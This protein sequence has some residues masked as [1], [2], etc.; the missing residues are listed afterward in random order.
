MRV[1]L[2]IILHGQT[3]RPID[4][5]PLGKIEEA[6]DHGVLRRGN[7]RPQ[8]I[9]GVLPLRAGEYQPLLTS[10]LFARRIVADECALFLSPA[11]FLPRKWPF[12]IGNERKRG[13]R[14]ENRLSCTPLPVSAGSSRPH[15][16]GSLTCNYSCLAS[17]GTLTR[18][19]SNIQL[20]L[21]LSF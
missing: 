3:R 16:P 2:V 1:S 20:L 10:A 5:Q 14:Q 17:R 7:Q 4:Q 18:F 6:Q 21:F 13:P 12:S 15:C 9:V 11:P 19:T 8:G